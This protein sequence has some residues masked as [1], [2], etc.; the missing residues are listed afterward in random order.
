MTFDSD[1]VSTKQL[2]RLAWSRSSLQSYRQDQKRFRQKKKTSP[3][4]FALLGFKEQLTHL[5]E[6]ERPVPSLPSPSPK[7]SPPVEWE[8]NSYQP[9]RYFSRGTLEADSKK[10]PSPILYLL[11]ETREKAQARPVPGPSVLLR[12]LCKGKGILRKTSQNFVY[13]DI[14]NRFI[15]SLVPYLPLYGLEKPPYFHLFF[16]PEGAHIPVIPAREMGFHYLEKIQ[17][18]GQE[19]SF[20]IEGLYSLEPTIWPEVEQVWFFKVHSPELETLR[21]R[22]FLPSLPGGHAFHIAIAVK[23]KITY[24]PS[25]NVLPTMRVNTTLLQSA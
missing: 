11:T 24:S 3:L 18:E 6:E 5:F 23:P 16:A 20:E 15:S 22:Y 25:T 21:R 13:L 1:W 7:L 19:F 17:E 8:T 14:D 2:Y 4:A 12:S 9:P 10:N